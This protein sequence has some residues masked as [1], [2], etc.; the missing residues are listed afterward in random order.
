MAGARIRITIEE[1][2]AGQS[3]LNQGEELQVHLLSGGL[4]MHWHP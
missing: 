1:R 4:R 2:R 3:D